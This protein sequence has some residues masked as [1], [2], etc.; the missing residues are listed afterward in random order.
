MGTGSFPGRKRP[1]RGIDHPPHLAPRL[2]KESFTSTPPLRLRGLFEG[3]LYILPLPTV[4]E[5]GWT[6]GPVWTSAENLASPGFDPRTVQPVAS[7]IG[8]KAFAHQFTCF[9]A[10]N[11]GRI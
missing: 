3:E 1:G 5:A 6:A 8:D 9:Q 7:V 11:Q 4:Q 2:K 10:D